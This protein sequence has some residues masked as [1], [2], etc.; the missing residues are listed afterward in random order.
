[1]RPDAS[2][3][4]SKDY[5]NQHLSAFQDGVAKIKSKA[6]VDIGPPV[7]TQNQEE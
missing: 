7:G 6:P 3:Y 4:L 1:M 5:I 2:T